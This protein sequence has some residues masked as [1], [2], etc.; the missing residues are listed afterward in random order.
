M[1]VK[2]IFNKNFAML[3]TLIS[4]DSILKEFET[5]K[6]TY[7]FMLDK[8]PVALFINSTLHAYYIVT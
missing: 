5:I 4:A 2:N 3:L 6:S 1:F 8:N 7:K